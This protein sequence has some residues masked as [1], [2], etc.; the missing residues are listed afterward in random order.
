DV[1]LAALGQL[2]QQVERA[3]EDA[4][5]ERER[6]RPRHRV[7][8]PVLTD[9]CFSPRSI[10]CRRSRTVLG[11]FASASRKDAT[12]MSPKTL[13]PLSDPSLTP[14]TSCWTCWVETTL[15]TLVSRTGRTEGSASY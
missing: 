2:Q 13:P 3:I 4:D 11:I 5:R 7:W 8:T 12:W 15:T 1:E 10:V 9:P 14:L 6:R